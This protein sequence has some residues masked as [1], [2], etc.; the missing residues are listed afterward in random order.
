MEKLVEIGT[1]KELSG[2]E[3]VVEVERSSACAH[4]VSRHLCFPEGVTN[5]LVRVANTPGAKPGDKVKLSLE[6]RTFLFLSF[7]VYMVPL[8][9]F[10]PGSYLGGIMS[11]YLLPGRDPQFFQFLFGMGA[12]GIGFLFARAYNRRL[13]KEKRCLVEITEII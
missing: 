10:F 13:T 12:V 3:A 2:G 11:V 5:L 9:L 7:L 6:G 4:C 8:L 1:V